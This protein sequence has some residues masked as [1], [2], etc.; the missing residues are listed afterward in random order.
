M[1][2]KPLLRKQGINYY[3]IQDNDCYVENK[4][5]IIG[6]ENEEVLLI[7]D[8]SPFLWD[9]S[10]MYAHLFDIISEISKICSL[11]IICFPF[12]LSVWR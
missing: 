1:R 7:V 2:I 6:M 12:C 3:K 11:F 5:F 8:G 10:Y 9:F 4:E